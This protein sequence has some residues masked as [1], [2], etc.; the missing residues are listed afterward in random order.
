MKSKWL[1]GVVAALFLA[2]LGAF[3]AGHV[4]AIAIAVT[5]N[6][7][8]P[9]RVQVAKGEP[10]KLVVTR[11]T[12]DTC[13]KQI[14]ITDEHIK[15]DLPLN[16]PVTLSFTPK[17]TGEIKYVCGMNMISGV[18]EVASSDASGSHHMTGTQGARD[19]QGPNSMDGMGEASGHPHDDASRATGCGCARHP[20][21]SSKG[22]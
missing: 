8:E 10:L 19:G 9:A 3:A 20:A 18:L 21:N 2:P 13:A 7:F 16:R 1:M 6:G 15:A 22:S 12:D 5:Q 11:K 14:V 17:R 4:R